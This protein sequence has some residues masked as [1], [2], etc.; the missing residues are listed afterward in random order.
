MRWTRDRAWVRRRAVSAIAGICVV[1]HAH[2]AEDTAVL[3]AVTVTGTREGQALN[4]TPAAVGIIPRASIERTRP[5]HP[6]QIIGQVPGAAVAVTNGEGHTT[7]IRQPFTTNPVY[8]FLE[9]GIP[10]RSTGFF[11]H[12]ALYEINIPQAGG[13]EVTRGPGSALYGSDAIGGIVNV[14]TRAPSG[15]PEFNLSGELGGHGFW[16]MLTGG[17]NGY[18]GGA[19]RADVN[20]THTDGWRDA[21]GYDRQSGTLRWDHFIGADA[22][23]KTVFAF[24]NIDQ[25]TGANSPLTTADF[26]N[27][28]TRNYLPIAF[29]KVQAF[30]LST[31]YEREIGNT[32]IS[33]TP[34]VRDNSMD[35]L[36]SFTLNFDPTISTVENQSYGLL[37]KWRVDFPDFMRARLIVGADIDV[38]PGER[39]EDSLNVSV[40]GAP[41]ARIFNSYSVARR[42]YDY[43]VT[44]RGISPYVH[45]EISPV[46][47]LRIVAGLRYDH[48]TYRFRNRLGGPPIFVAPGA[49]FPGARFYGQANDADPKFTHFSPKLGATY[50][51]GVNTHAFVGYSHG[52]RAPSEGNLFRPAVGFSAAAATRA[53]QTALTLEPIKADQVEAGVRGS[54]GR[55]AYDLVVYH[56]RK[57]DDIVSQRDPVTTFSQTVNAGSTRHRGVELGVGAAVMTNVRLDVAFSYAKHKYEDWVTT[58]GVFSGK[59]IEAAPRVMSTS[60]LTWQPRPNAQAQLEWV[61]LGHYWLDAAN[62]QTYG[63]HD[64]FNLR[65]NWPVA[66]DVGVFGSVYNIFDKRY[67]D[68]AQLSSSQPVLSPGLPRT[69]YAGVEA[70]W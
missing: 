1:M 58:A 5:N 46:E 15:K 52:F 24:S 6:S 43:D 25:Q 34:Y 32:L 31:N 30:R 39:R 55:V 33:L 67:A 27:N 19:W 3:P 12:N 17:G 53:A 45:G 42:V 50:A 2:A 28:P 49:P 63:G 56:L 54:A 8:L 7:A 64:L 13:I 26:R 41:P 36:A 35:L 69:F 48:L 61:R 44:F 16:R 59:E 60:R 21:T 20:F 9:D 57:R 51:L 38:S 66:K 29:R 68:S 14:L 11:N 22:S 65:A 47:R 70:K 40:S 23:L 62:T 18:N 4:E 37:A 10:I